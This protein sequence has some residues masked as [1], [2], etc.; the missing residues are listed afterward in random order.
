MRNLS[1]RDFITGKRD[2]APR[3]LI[4]PKGGTVSEVGSGSDSPTRNDEQ[5]GCDSHESGHNVTGPVAP[6]PSSFADWYAMHGIP[7]GIGRDNARAI[8][9]AAVREH[10][11]AVIDAMSLYNETMERIEGA[12]AVLYDKWLTAGHRRDMNEAMDALSLALGRPALCKHPHDFPCCAFKPVLDDQLEA[13]EVCKPH[14]SKIRALL[15][16]ARNCFPAPDAGYCEDCAQKLEPVE[17]ARG[18]TICQECQN[19]TAPE[20]TDNLP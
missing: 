6:S 18:E 2:P 1:N 14:I 19:P 17:I 10:R 13:C 8:Y 16:G 11:Q 3:D 20:Q 7:L 9:E 4:T 12:F 5:T 15:G